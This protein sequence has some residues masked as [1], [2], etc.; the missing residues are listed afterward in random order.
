VDAMCARVSES[1]HRALFEPR[2]AE[3][4][5]GDARWPLRMVQWLL[6]IIYLS[7]ALWKLTRGRAA[8]CVRGAR[9][10]S[11]GAGMWE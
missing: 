7:A 11:G 4:I 1:G 5:G 9:V 10:E 8:R 3:A 2:E 6:V